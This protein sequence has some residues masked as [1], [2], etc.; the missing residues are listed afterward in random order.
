M[1][2]AKTVGFA[3]GALLA[4]ISL[5]CG[6][7]VYAAPN[8]AIQIAGYLTHSTIP[9]VIRPF[10]PASFVIGLV[11]WAVFGFI[12]GFVFAKLCGCCEENPKKQ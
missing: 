4:G 5:V 12:I 7:V 8:I 1:R 9:F 10:D 3:L 6:I 11:L 2:D